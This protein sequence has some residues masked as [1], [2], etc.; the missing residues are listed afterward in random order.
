MAAALPRT[1]RRGDRRAQSQAASQSPPHC[2][3]CGAASHRAAIALS[4]LGRAQIASAAG[5][6]RGADTAQHDSP[7]SAASRFDW[8]TGTWNG[9][10]AAFRAQ[11]AQRA[12]ADGLQGAKGMA[13]AYGAAV[14]VGRS[15]PLP[16][17][18]GGHGR[19]ACPTGAT[20]TGR[21]LSA[22]R[23]SGRD[24][25]GPWHALVEHARAVRANA[26]VVMADAPR[27]SAVLE[28]RSASPNPG[29]SGTFS[30][31]A[32][33]AWERR[34]VPQQNRQAWL[35]EYRWEHNHVRPHE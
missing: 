12:V 10:G 34:G 19:H 32:A 25:D 14:G 22:L 31:I 2:L 4:R 28:W 23:G 26:V 20:A 8:D 24:V 9:G 15:Q 29:Q 30:W 6:R 27:H 7:H 11:S 33:T 17:R 3:R 16:D 35:D 21:S 18:A 13:A 1:G 5:A